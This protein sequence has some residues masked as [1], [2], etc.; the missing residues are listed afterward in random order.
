[1][2]ETFVYWLICRAISLSNKEMVRN[3]NHPR[4]E[5]VCNDIRYPTLAW[6]QKAAC[7]CGRTDFIFLSNLTVTRIV[8]PHI[9][10]NNS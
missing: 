4:D 5:R 6:V 3:D 2:A 7:G 9:S 8:L 10:I 1:M